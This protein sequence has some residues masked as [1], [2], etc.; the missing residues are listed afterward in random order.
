MVVADAEDA[1]FGP[2]I[3]AR[4][5]MVVRE[6]G[7]SVAI[8]AVIFA[9]RAPGTLGQ[10]RPPALPVFF[11]SFCFVKT[12]VFRRKRRFR[13]MV[14]QRTRRSGSGVTDQAT[15]ASAT[16]SFKRMLVFA[17]GVRT[18]RHRT[19]LQILLD[20]VAAAA[21]RTLLG[22][23][24]APSDEVALGV[25]IAAV[26]SPAA[27]RA[28]LHNFALRAVRARDA[29]GLLLNV[30]A[31][32][33]IAAGDKLAVASK[34][35]HQVAL[36]L[37]AFLF[38]RNIFA[39]LAADLFGRLAIGVTGAGEEL[40]EAALLQNHGPAAVLAVLLLVLLADLGLFAVRQIERDFAGVGALRIAGAGNEAAV[41][42]PL[43]HHGLA[44]LFADEV[45]RLLHPLD[46]G[47]VPRG[48]LQILLEAAVEISHGHSPFEFAVFD[49]VQL[50]FHARRVLH[51]E[52]VVEALKQQVRN[53]HTQLGRAELAAFLA[54]VLAILNG[55][56][57]GRVG[58]RTAHAVGFELLHKRRF[59]VARRRL[60]EMLLG[61]NFLEP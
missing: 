51:V 55:G 52:Q 28:A 18:L 16:G 34:L 2:A 26:E 48:M 32:R 39:L 24:F 3:S 50:F 17:L 40:P 44:A 5:R 25:A 4:T 14:R 19:C 30:L 38:E 49:L 9:N 57:D 41:L 60:S 61:Q 56:Q 31:F 33:V 27:L 58:R 1:V 20:Q 23:R 6:I 21:L 42:A 37:R 29:N 36:A 13:H 46:V 35:L 45:G 8:R 7:P 53:H 43:D 10:V 54:D 22:N 12:L 47:H 15:L 11:V 59:V